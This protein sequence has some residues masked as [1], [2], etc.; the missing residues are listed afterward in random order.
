MTRK[1]TSSTKLFFIV[2]LNLVYITLRALFYPKS[3]QLACVLL[4][5]FFKFNSCTYDK[6]SL[7]QNYWKRFASTTFT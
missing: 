2:K 1:Q 3:S 5:V 7:N 4:S 6:L